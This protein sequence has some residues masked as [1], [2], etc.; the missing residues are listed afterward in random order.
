MA[1]IIRQAVRRSSDAREA[2]RS[3]RRQPAARVA[4]AGGVVVTSLL[5]AGP[6]WAGPMLGC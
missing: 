6:A 2:Q 3:L 5:I 4:V 1:L